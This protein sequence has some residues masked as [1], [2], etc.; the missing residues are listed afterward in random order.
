MK[1]N[2]RENREGEGKKKGKRKGNQREWG[3]KGK[4]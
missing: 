4:T 2:V 3:G 1:R